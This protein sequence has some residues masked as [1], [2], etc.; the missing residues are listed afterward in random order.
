MAKYSSHRGSSY[1]ALVR[2]YNKDFPSPSLQQTEVDIPRTFPEEDYFKERV[3]R[4]RLQRVLV[5]Y[6]VR[7]PMI[8]YCQGFNFVVGRMLQV[9]EEEVSRGAGEVVTQGVGRVLV[10]RNGGGDA[11]AH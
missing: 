9:M 3:N 2:H 5:A 8:G 7:N 6:S 4:E 11:H 1:E 10:V